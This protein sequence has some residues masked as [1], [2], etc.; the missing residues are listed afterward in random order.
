M[1][2]RRSTRAPAKKATARKMVKK[3]M[4]KRAPVSNKLKS[5]VKRVIASNVENKIAVPVTTINDNINNMSPAAFGT[6]IELSDVWEIAQGTGQGNR[7]GN[8]I[9]PVKWNFKGFISLDQTGA[10]ITL[11]CIV[12]MYVLKY[13]YG[14]QSPPPTLAPTD[15]YQNGSTSSAPLGNFLDIMR[16]VNDDVYTVYTTRTFKVGPANFSYGTGA[17]GA[18]NNN[19]FKSVIPFNINLMKYQSHKIKYFDTTNT[20]TNSG[21]HVVFAIAPAD[22][23]QSVGGTNVNLPNISYDITGVYEDA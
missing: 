4:K 10:G 15:F 13:K 5:Y 21:L 14:Y 22:G 17:S 18:I 7:I 23:S 11:P 19:D 12:K 6:V 9:K 20:P 1:V 16:A 8:T 2:Y 3:V